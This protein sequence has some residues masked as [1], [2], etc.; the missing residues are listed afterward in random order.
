MHLVASDTRGNGICLSTKHVDTDTAFALH[1][2]LRQL[3]LGLFAERQAPW[4][5]LLLVASCS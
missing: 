4:S 3:P 2:Q 1:G 5:I